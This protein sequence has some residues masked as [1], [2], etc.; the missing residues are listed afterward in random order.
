MQCLSSLT[1]IYTLSIQRS[2]LFSSHS[3]ALERA[4]SISVAYTMEYF[5][6]CQTRLPTVKKMCETKNF[7]LEADFAQ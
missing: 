1:Y 7:P 3:R 5:N 6:N 4:R 2:C